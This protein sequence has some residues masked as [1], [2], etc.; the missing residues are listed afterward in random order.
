MAQYLLLL[1]EDPNGSAALAP[2]EM[3]A[4]IEKYQAW[5][6]GI[7]ESGRLLG[8]NKLQDEGGRQL[9]LND[10]SLRVI[11]GPFSEAKEVIGGYFLIEAAD[12]EDAVALAGDCPHLEFGGRIELRAIHQLG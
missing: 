2:A 7:A 8:S 11:D 12:Y 10:G 4:I 3:Q 9:T 1:H 6:D 5:S